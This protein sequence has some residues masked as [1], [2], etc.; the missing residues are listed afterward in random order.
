MNSLMLHS[1]TARHGGASA[2]LSGT[3]PNLIPVTGE[4]G[5]GRGRSDASHNFQNDSA[6]TARIWAFEA[7]LFVPVHGEYI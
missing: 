2:L 5:I 6:N 3:S 4:A 1:E 7:F